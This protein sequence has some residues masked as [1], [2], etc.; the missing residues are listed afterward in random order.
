MLSAL[1][2]ILYSLHGI[3]TSN[4]PILAVYFEFIALH[5]CTPHHNHAI[6][7][8]NFQ[9]HLRTKEQPANV[10]LWDKLI[11]RKIQKNVGVCIQYTKL[12]TGR[13]SRSRS[14]SSYW[15]YSM[16]MRQQNACDQIMYS[17]SM[18]LAN[19]VSPTVLLRRAA[20]RTFHVGLGSTCF[21]H[22]LN[23]SLRQCC[24]FSG[25]AHLIVSS[26]PSSS[27][28]RSPRSYHLWEM[29]ISSSYT[30]ISLIGFW[31]VG[32]KHI[33]RSQ[34]LIHGTSIPEQ[35]LLQLI[36]TC[37]QWKAGCGNRLGRRSN[38]HPA[39]YSTTKF[40]TTQYQDVVPMHAVVIRT[41][42]NCLH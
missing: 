22:V 25:L 15:R 39:C 7:Q 33:A 27:S 9:C 5:T 41:Q 3:Y 40:G 36:A 23:V 37:K 42:F 16:R 18:V 35:S 32:N 19:F 4:L 17:A 38:V 31:T 14:E 12:Q 24:G 20:H 10:G 30:S 29:P 8:P 11:Q 26:F 34:L 28:S 1:R 13:D 2:I 21:S 6:N